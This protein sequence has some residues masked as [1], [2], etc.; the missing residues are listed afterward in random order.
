M[1]LAGT[2][3]DQISSQIASMIKEKDEFG[4]FLY[5]FPILQQ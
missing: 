2:S 4:A 1:E 3:F 5:A